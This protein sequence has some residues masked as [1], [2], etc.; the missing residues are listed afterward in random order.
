MTIILEHYSIPE[1]GTFEIHQ[2]V[3]VHISAEEAKRNVARW[4]RRDVSHLLGADEPV[5]VIGKQV[6]WRVPTHFSLPH[7]GVL[8]QTGEV[9]VDALSGELLD[10]TESRVQIEECARGLAATAPPFQSQKTVPPAYMP[11]DV[12]TA[13]KLLLDDEQT[14]PD[15]LTA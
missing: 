9:Y 8:G 5:L 15:S 6:R 4:L 3:T 7:V 1:T 13:P 10:Q 14:L 12:P 11:T 2:T